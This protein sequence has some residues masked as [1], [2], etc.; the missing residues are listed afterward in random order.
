MAALARAEVEVAATAPADS[1]SYLGAPR[2]YVF[3]ASLTTLVGLLVF[4]GF[5]LGRIAPPTSD[6]AIAVPTSESVMSAAGSE[7]WTHALRSRIEPSLPRIEVTRNGSM[8]EGQG[9][10]FTEQGHILTSAALVEDASHTV[11]WFG[12]LRHEGTVIA[13]DKLT[14]V[15]VVQV[16]DPPAVPA[17]LG[18]RHEAQIGQHALTLD[19]RAGLQP[20]R[21][22]SLGAE[23]KLDY[24]RTFYGLLGVTTPNDLQPGAA[25]FDDAGIVIG[26]APMVPE[27]AA[28]LFHPV[29][30]NSPSAPRTG[31]VIPI[32]LVQRVAA[33]FVTVGYVQHA[34]L[35][36]TGVDSSPEQVAEVG[37]VGAAIVIDVEAEGPADLGGLQ[38]GDLIV[39]VGE[40]PVRSMADLV[41]ALRNHEP[42]AKLEVLTFRESRLVNQT[43]TLGMRDSG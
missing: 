25:V 21:I 4:G 15:A 43:V 27:A 8:S 24:G 19:D 20:G 32:S 31:Q 2:R 3:A 33:E 34:W 37:L 18:V 30:T 6:E 5:Q 13:A 17:V 40:A 39:Q 26:M 38:A 35:G 22:A 11:V 23:V 42:D 1:T 9:I 16:A 14:D 36:I 10:L 7:S 28:S 29:S 41:L 12:N